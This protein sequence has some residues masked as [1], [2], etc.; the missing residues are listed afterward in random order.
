L[1]FLFSN[2]FNRQSFSEGGFLENS[3]LIESIVMIIPTNEITK[4]KPSFVKPKITPTAVKQIPMG[5]RIYFVWL[6]IVTS[7]YAYTK[8]I[9][10]FKKWAGWLLQR[11]R[12]TAGCPTAPP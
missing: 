4:K 8:K 11:Q 7:L 6:L 10:S 12:R 1:P 3:I 2:T 9:I 5:S